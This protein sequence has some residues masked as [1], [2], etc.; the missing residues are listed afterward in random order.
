MKSAASFTKRNAHIS[1]MK[2]K[3]FDLVVVG[4]GITGAGVVRDAAMRGL[5]VCLIDRGDFGEG[6]SS[7]SSK[8]AHGGLRYLENFEFDLVSEALHERQNLLQMA[9]HMV[10]P[11][12][13]LMPLYKG[14]RVGPLKM[15]AGMILYDLLS[16]FRTPKFHESISG[17]KIKERYPKIKSEGLRSGFLYSDA[18]MDDDRLVYETLSSAT[19]YGAVVASYVSAEDYKV[20]DGISVLTC[21]DKFSGDTFK[22]KGLHTA[23]CVGP[24]TDLFAKKVSPDWKDRMRPSKGIHITLPKD[25]LKL[26]TA[27]VMAS[28]KEKRILFCIPREDFDIIGTTDTDFG[29]DPSKVRSQIEDVDY[30]INILKEYYPKVN[31]TYKD[32]LFSYSGVRP[33]VNDG[34]EDESKVSRS[35][36][37]QTDKEN[38]VTYISGGKYTTYL[39][40]AEHCVKDILKNSPLLKKKSH[41]AN[42]RVP[43]VELNSIENMEFAKIRIKESG[44]V[45]WT[46][47]AINCFVDR[48]GALAFSHAQ[49]WPSKSVYELEALIAIHYYFCGS[50]KDFY[51]RRVP[52]LL[53]GLDF[54]EK[55]YDEVFQVFM[56]ELGWSDQNLDKNKNELQAAI[57]FETGW[58]N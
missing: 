8:L 13:F 25:I 53:Q 27:V 32:I 38:K 22:I 37:I 55:T 45:E 24:W 18:L 51:F 21:K 50:L 17:R 7:R 16:S 11:L 57:E 19:K 30:V 28:D 42:T 43:F 31:I 23:S 36:W 33:L 10:K 40:M 56:R 1:Q 44:L 52:Y 4:G 9:P 20:E 49:K 34:S 26:D 5:S 35:H 12:R 47:D 15:K 48:H 58:R 41:K 2:D 54:A 46:Q 6:T 29:K 39:A 3:V 14:D